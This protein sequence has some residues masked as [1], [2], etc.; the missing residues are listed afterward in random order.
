MA[1]GF[2]SNPVL[3]HSIT[4][5]NSFLTSHLVLLI[6]FRR[7]PPY[8]ILFINLI[9]GNQINVSFARS[10]PSP[11]IS[12]A[13]NCS[14][15]EQLFLVMVLSICSTSAQKKQYSN[16]LSQMFTILFVDSCC[17][18]DAIWGRT[19][20]D[21]SFFLQNSSRASLIRFGTVNR[22]LIM[23]INHLFQTAQRTNVYS[24]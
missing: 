7:C 17:Y 6:S 13:Y 2:Q 3:F 15:I 10:A 23:H 16:Q 19:I 18:I 20:F 4:I 24:P 14:Q 1:L 5:S 12:N 9:N 21:R 22:Q 11:Q 8:L